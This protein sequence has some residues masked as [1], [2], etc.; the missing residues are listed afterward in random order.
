MKKLSTKFLFRVTFLLA[1]VAC[2]FFLQDPGATFSSH[3]QGP[4]PDERF[5]LETGQ[6]V[7][8]LS[9]EVLEELTDIHLP[10]RLYFAHADGRPE[11][12]V[13]GRFEN[14]L[15]TASGREL[16]TIPVGRYDVYV[17]RGIE[18]TLDHQEVEILE[19][20][21]THFT[22]T[23]SRAIDTSGYISSD[24]HLHLQFAMRDGAIVSAAA[25]LDLLTATDHNILKDYS[26]YIEELNLGRFMSSV[27]GSEIDTAFGHFN[28]FPM[29]LNRWQERSYRYSI[30]TP[31]E[32]L[33]L[34]RQNPGDEI[35]QINHPR[36]G[37]TKGGYFN[38]RLNRDTG[39]I[40]YPFFET[41]F[42]QVEVYNALT[43]LEDRENPR[44]GR[45]QRLDQNLKDWYS[46]LNRGIAI[47]GVGNTDAHRYPSELP[48][49]PRNYV[50]SDTDKPWEI[51]PYEV[52]D[53]LK[54]GASSASLGPFI[55]FT[56]DDGVQ[57]GSTHTARDGSV[58]V[59]VNVQRAPWIPLDRVEIVANG[60]VLKTLSTEEAPEGTRHHWDIEVKADQDTWLLVLATSDRPWEKPFTHFSSF[61]FT[62]PIWV[63]FDGNGYFD[64]PNPGYPAN[65]TAE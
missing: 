53:A 19:G 45:N 11:T 25:G 5:V 65:E 50:L 54:R 26:P 23:L 15:V 31:G 43:V 38:T 57:M 20:K 32:F 46:L 64:P 56:V 16:K 29:S 22:S 14:Y 8:E 48:G 21:R 37:T 55:R 40:E 63:D 39:E 7:G 3:D 6:P 44:F 10:S 27:V 12:P 18:Y 9:F 13:V 28:S 1:G 60:K 34:M 58:M 36:Y 35:V 4:D 17:S 41:S 49:Y 2:W 51:D 30:L 61:A 59:H 33:R 24:F 62:N 42:N 52:V 47:T